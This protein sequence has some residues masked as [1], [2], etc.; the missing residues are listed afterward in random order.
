MADPEDKV[1]S[2]EK[3][4]HD[5]MTAAGGHVEHA[6]VILN[7]RTRWILS[8][9]RSTPGLKHW[10]DEKPMSDADA[11]HRPPPPEPLSP[12]EKTALA[13]IEGDADFKKDIG[14]LGLTPEHVDYVLAM[15]NVAAAHFRSTTEVL[16]GGM[17]KQVIDCGLEEQWWR[18]ALKQRI[19]DL[20]DQDRFPLGTEVRA[21][22]FQEARQIGQLLRECGA[23]IIEAN[24]VAYRGLLAAALMRQQAR[25]GLQNKKPGFKDA[26]P[27]NRTKH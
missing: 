12:D 3:L 15:R 27:V 7:K 21:A 6:A 16:H 26:T 9:L 22:V 20:K 25:E 2:E 18:D 23:Q 17:V 11:L 4:I 5:A 8:R 13:I 19:E 24:Q 10:L 1:E 14:K